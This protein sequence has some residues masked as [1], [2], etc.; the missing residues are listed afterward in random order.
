MATQQGIRWREDYDFPQTILGDIDWKDYRLSV[1]VMLPQ[2]GSVKVQGRVRGFSWGGQMPYTAYELE[3]NSDGG[4]VLRAGEKV[5]ANGRTE[6][7]GG[8]WHK[9]SLTFNKDLI[10]TRL[11]NQGVSEVHDTANPNG[12]IGLGSGWNT[13]L[14]DNLRINSVN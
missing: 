1:D 2:A 12:V 6:P 11:D 8:K 4:W 9:V 5:L 3:W 10:L 14:F 7:L 13:A